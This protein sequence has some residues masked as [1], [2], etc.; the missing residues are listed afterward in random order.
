MLIFATERFLLFRSG[1]LTAM[2]AT[3]WL[4]VLLTLCAL[5]AWR[6]ASG[7][8]ETLRP[9]PP[10]ASPAPDSEATS[11]G[12]SSARRAGVVALPTTGPVAAAGRSGVAGTPDPL[13]FPSQRFEPDAY[14]MPRMAI[15]G[16]FWRAAEEGWD[17][18]RFE[19]AVTE[20]AY[21]DGRQSYQ[22]YV[23][24]R[25][26]LDAPR[27]EGQYGDF[28]ERLEGAATGDLD[29]RQLRRLTR[30]LDRAEAGL[31][32]CE[33][34]PGDLEP[35]ALEWLTRAAERG[36]PLAQIA[37]YQSFRWLSGRKPY[38]LFGERD[39]LWRYRQLAPAFLE[40]ALGSGHPE[41]FVEMGRALADGVVFDENPAEAYAYALAAELAG[42]RATIGRELRAELAVQLGSEQQGEA[43]DR[44]RELCDR[45]CL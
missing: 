2:S 16:R 33:G 13:S 29:E 42:E 25:T 8:S 3:R 5:V 9:S 38:L 10:T 36:Y 40:A 28:L 31:V 6:L 14:E 21:L 27:T 17:S 7:P 4:L 41:A 12:A 26:C 22:A 20:K 43:R 34:L 39:G 32:R 15:F 23:Y 19:N 24:L 1:E 18:R 30:V 45:Y 37:Y 35:L 44:A 11:P